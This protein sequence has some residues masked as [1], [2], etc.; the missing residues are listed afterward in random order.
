MLSVLYLA[1]IAGEE[2]QPASAEVQLIPAALAR[3]QQQRP[4]L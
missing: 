1:D 2:L 4:G 3:P